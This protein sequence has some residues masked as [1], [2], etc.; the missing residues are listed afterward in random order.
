MATGWG[1]G[2]STQHSNS[3]AFIYKVN[4]W[5][6]SVGNRM[7]DKWIGIFNASYYTLAHTQVFQT[8]MGRTR[9]RQY[10]LILICCSELPHIAIL[11][12]LSAIESLQHSVSK[13]W[14][15]EWLIHKAGVMEIS[16]QSSSSVSTRSVWN[17]SACFNSV[18]DH[19]ALGWHR[20]RVWLHITDNAM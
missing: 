2:Y 19:A 10:R 12:A 13:Q 1:K 15:Y 16:C 4:I 8:G 18:A 14:L 7:S 20:I 5:I 6:Y 17:I 3:T 9:Q 11:Y